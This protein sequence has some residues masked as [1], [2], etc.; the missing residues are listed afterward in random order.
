MADNVK[1]EQLVSLGG[2]IYSGPH[3]AAISA[4]SSGDNT[5]VAAAGAHPDSLL[6]LKIK[7]TS[8]VL[9][10]AS[11]VNVRFEDGAGGTALSGVMTLNTAPGIICGYNPDGWF[12]TS[13][14]T[15]LNLELSGAVQVSGF[16]T[17][18]LEV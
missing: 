4:A 1:G 5:L 7:V 11:S 8:V 12:I 10:A 6:G 18:V 16:L 13:G 15:L 2:N 3:R 14:N 9:M 17:Y